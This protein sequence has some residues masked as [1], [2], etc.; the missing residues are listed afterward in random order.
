MYLLPGPCVDGTQPTGKRIPS[1]TIATTPAAER[2]AA[3]R[4]DDL[5][6]EQPPKWDR[7]PSGTEYHS[8]LSLFWYRVPTG[9][10]YQTGLS[11]KR[12]RVPRRAER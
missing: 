6:V 7:V 1:A 5:E 2:S 8:G 4:G 12:D 10:Q 3:P 9:A 11:T